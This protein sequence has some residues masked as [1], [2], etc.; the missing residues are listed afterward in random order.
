MFNSHTGLPGNPYDRPG[1]H[2]AHQG[3]FNALMTMAYEQRTANLIAAL[4][5]LYPK[6]SGWA[7]EREDLREQ[8]AQRLGLEY[9]A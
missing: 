4:D 8:I 2:E 1:A 6:A 5:A 3:Q 7:E 9:R